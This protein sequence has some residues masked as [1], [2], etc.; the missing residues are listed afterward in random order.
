[1][2]NT[3]STWRSHDLPKITIVSVPAD[4]R[5][6]TFLSS[7]GCTPFLAV[8]P[9]AHNLALFNLRLDAFS[10]NSISLGLEPG[11]PASI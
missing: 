5:A 9:N 4:K 11:L 2:F 8:L 1:M 10:K 6:F 3:F 7:L